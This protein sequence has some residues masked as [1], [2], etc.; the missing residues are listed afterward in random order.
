MLINQFSFEIFDEE[1]LVLRHADKRLFRVNSSALAVLQILI[2]TNADIDSAL[3]RADQ[4]DTETTS[5]DIE[6]VRSLLLP[7]RTSD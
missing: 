1:A 4:V 7:D 2:D 3:N 5:E 6:L